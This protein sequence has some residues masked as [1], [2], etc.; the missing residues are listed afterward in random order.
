MFIT[1]LRTLK[2]TPFVSVSYPDVARAIL[3]GL[4]RAGKTGADRG[5]ITELCQ[6]I[7]S[8]KITSALQQLDARGLIIVI[9]RYCVLGVS[10]IEHYVIDRFTSTQSLILSELCRA[11]SAKKSC[12][13]ITRLN[14]IARS[15]LQPA[16]KKLESLGYISITRG[17]SEGRNPRL[18]YTLNNLVPMALGPLEQKNNSAINKQQASI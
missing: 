2:D 11:P 6:G 7:A 16:A 3:N 17:K 8:Y 13:D 10:D 15:Q 9:G 1:N 4:R 14:P 5:A 18:Y 12:T